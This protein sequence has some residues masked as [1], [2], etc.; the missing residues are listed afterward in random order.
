[1]KV[2]QNWISYC[3][4]SRVYLLG[5]QNLIIIVNIVIQEFGLGCPR[6][7]LRLLKESLCFLWKYLQAVQPGAS[8]VNFFSN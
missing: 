1:M 5:N 8:L 4:A 7:A 2:F 3:R 6:S